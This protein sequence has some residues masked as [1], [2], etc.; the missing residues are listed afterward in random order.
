ME[1]RI[2]KNKN[3]KNRLLYEMKSLHDTIDWFGHT[4]FYSLK[5]ILPIHKEYYVILMGYE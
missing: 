2:T 4:S 1:F 3:H 5:E